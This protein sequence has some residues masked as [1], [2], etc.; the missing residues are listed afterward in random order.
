MARGEVLPVLAAQRR[1]VDAELH[2][3]GGFGDVERRQGFRVLAVGDALAQSDAGHARQRDDLSRAGR[4]YGD[5][6][7]PLVDEQLRD[8]GGSLGPGSPA[9]GDGLPVADR[10]GHDPSDSERTEVVVG[11][12]VGHQHLQGQVGFP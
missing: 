7:E 3:Q 12:D 6:P 10:T 5:S 2:R 8:G 4:R 11:L 1:V 9:H